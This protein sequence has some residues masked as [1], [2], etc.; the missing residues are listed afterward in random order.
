MYLTP[1]TVLRRL[2]QIHVC[3]FF[4]LLTVSEDIFDIKARAQLEALA[5]CDTVF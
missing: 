4:L 2:L 1:H 3:L 5:W